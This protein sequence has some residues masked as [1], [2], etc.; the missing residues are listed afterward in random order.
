MLFRIERGPYEARVAEIEG[1]IAAAEAELNL[2][3]IERDRQRTLVERGSVAQSTLDVANAEL[4]RALGQVQ[5]LKGSLQRAKLELGYTEI[6]APFDGIVG[7][8]SW[9]VGAFV[10]PDSGA[11]VTLVRQDPMSVEFAIPSAWAFRIRGEGR[12]AGD[13]ACR[14]RLPDGAIYEE[15]GVIDFVDVLVN[16]G[17]DT[18]ALRAQFPN[19]DR[20]LVHGALVGVLLSEDDAELELSIPQQAIQQDL[21]GAFVMIVDEDS[22]AQQRRVV[23]ERYAE[24]RAVIASGLE[25]GETV[26]VE[27]INKARPGQPVDAAPAVAPVRGG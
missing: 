15:E 6:A 27:G 7:L 4:G 17:T 10:G 1:Q 19:P 11:L 25:E 16:Q 13:V 9:D 23:V 8:T 14:I 5:Q 22:N 3:T 21:L 12:R 18:I 20:L 26:I 24:G 2:A